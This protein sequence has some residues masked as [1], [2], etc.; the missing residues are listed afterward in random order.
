M[1][2]STRVQS[3][4]ITRTEQ[5]TYSLQGQSREEGVE[6]LSDV[7]A[8]VRASSFVDTIADLEATCR[9][10]LDWNTEAKQQEYGSGAWYAATLIE[11]IEGARDVLRRLLV[12]ADLSPD[13][14]AFVNLAAA[15][16]MAIGRLHAEATA[17]RWDVVRIG[18]KRRAQVVAYQKKGVE[19]RRRADSP[20]LARAVAAYQK[21][22]PHSSHAE[23]A[24]FL[25]R[26]FGRGRSVDSL[27]TAIS[28]IAVK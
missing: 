13:A 5:T 4:G 25:H 23:I 10:V 27:R 21:K 17:K 16:A 12:V 3:D 20:E 22:K 7:K 2:K 26:D 19:A 28:R 11:R 8:H 18:Q 1:A 14:R 24:R 15:Q 6:M 9:R